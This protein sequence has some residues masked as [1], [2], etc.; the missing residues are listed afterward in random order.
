M[1]RKHFLPDW[2][3]IWSFLRDGSSDW[4]PKVVAVAAIVYLIWPI[5]LLP[6]L[7]PLIGWL[8]DIGFVGFATW[9]LMH[10][11]AEHQKKLDK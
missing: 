6:D 1:S 8:D 3:A 4:K 7:A 11:S 5:D 9:Y 10:A 2:K